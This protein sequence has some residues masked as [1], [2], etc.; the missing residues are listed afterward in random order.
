M[1]EANYT[2]AVTQQDVTSELLG[3]SLAA[4]TVS[5]QKDVLQYKKPLPRLMER[6]GNCIFKEE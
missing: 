4:R 5:E 6:T 1:A 2:E 3:I